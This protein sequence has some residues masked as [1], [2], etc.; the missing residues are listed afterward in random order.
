MRH[1]VQVCIE[2]A[3]KL[4]R[5]ENRRSRALDQTGLAQARLVPRDFEAAVAAGNQAIEICTAGRIRGSA[6]GRS[7]R[8]S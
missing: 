1:D 4:L 3:V 5:P 2:R 6:C 8:F 7:V